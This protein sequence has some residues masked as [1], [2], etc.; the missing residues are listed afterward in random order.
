M[1]RKSVIIAAELGWGRDDC[2]EMNRGQAER[3]STP[4]KGKRVLRRFWAGDDLKL[5]RSLFL[6][7]SF[8]LHRGMLEFSIIPKG[9]HVIEIFDRQRHQ[10]L[11]GLD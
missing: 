7:S 6:C 4:A 2:D 1:G 8:A 5:R 9:T 10:N 11:V 3:R